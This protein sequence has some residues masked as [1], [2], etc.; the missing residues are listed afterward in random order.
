MKIL[1]I[2]TETGGLSSK[3][4]DMTEISGIIDIDGNPVEE[5]QLLLQPSMVR[6][7][8]S[9]ALILQHRTLDEVMAHP[10]SQ[11]EGR[12]EIIKIMSRYV[13]RYD[14]NDK[15]IWAGQ[16]PSFD[17]GFAQHWWKTQGD[18]YF[19]AWF[20]YHP[21]DLMAVMAALKLRGYFSS[22]QNFKL[23]SICKELRVPLID[24]HNAL[25]DIRATR[26]AFYI[27]IDLIPW[28]PGPS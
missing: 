16:N 6:R 12:Q 23:E 27:A 5:F 25:S 24:A 13:D 7:V 26:T 20:D 19:G 9:E 17:M 15:F 1:W 21:I 14:R 3:D 10:L 28:G 2:D 4:H 11:H 8:T 22:L 18:P